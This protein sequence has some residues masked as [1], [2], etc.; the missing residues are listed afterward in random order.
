MHVIIVAFHY[1]TIVKC[2]LISMKTPIVF[3]FPKYNLHSSL[4]LNCFP[5]G[6]CIIIYFPILF[7]IYRTL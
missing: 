1:A 3:R 2:E 7:I 6:M 4:L 5:D